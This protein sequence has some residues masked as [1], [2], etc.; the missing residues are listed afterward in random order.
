MQ[1]RNRAVVF[2]FQGGRRC[3]PA[4]ERR[5]ATRRPR[6]PWPG[7]ITERGTGKRAWTSGDEPVAA[8]Q[9]GLLATGVADD[10]RGDA[11]GTGRADDL[12]FSGGRGLGRVRRYLG[13]G[14]WLLAMIPESEW[15]VNGGGIVGMRGGPIALT[16][17]LLPAVRAL[18]RARLGKRDVGRGVVEGGGA[19]SPHRPHG[20]CAPA[21]SGTSPD[22]LGKRI[23]ISHVRSF[24]AYNDPPPQLAWGGA[25]ARTTSGRT[26]RRRRGLLAYH[27]P[28]GMFLS[29]RGCH[30]KGVDKKCPTPGLRCP[31]HI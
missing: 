6:G 15:G 4:A 30:P 27:P 17:A 26:P 3:S 21:G 28:P 2:C 24:R 20:R 7:R 11:G 31:V 1:N 22:E 9:G 10:H 13:R 12:V 23:I 18:P 19:T 16:V 29:P 5:N 25:G 8:G 14:A